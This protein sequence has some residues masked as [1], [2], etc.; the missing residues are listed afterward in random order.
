MTELERLVNHG[1]YSQ[2]CSDSGAARKG[3][4]NH[5]AF[6][7]DG[8]SAQRPGQGSDAGPSRSPRQGRSDGDLIRADRRAHKYRRQGDRLPGRARAETLRCAATADALRERLRRDRGMRLADAEIHRGP[9]ARIQNSRQIYQ[10]RRISC[11]AAILNRSDAADAGVFDAEPDVL[12]ESDT[13]RAAGAERRGAGSADSE[14]EE[15]ST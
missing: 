8:G 4:T 12:R 10:Q 2:W 13:E 3:E 5:A 11:G 7:R 6:R 14:S 15:A 9:A 1:R